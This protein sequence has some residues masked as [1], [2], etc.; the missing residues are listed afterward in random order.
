MSDKAPRKNVISVQNEDAVADNN[1]SECSIID[2]A[3]RRFSR[4]SVGA[5]VLMT[6]LSKP[7]FGAQ[8]LSNMLSGNLSDPNRGT[9][10]KGDSPGG[11]KQPGGM[12]KG[13]P[14]LTA[15]SEAGFVYGEYDS[16]KGNPSQ[17][18]SYINGSLAGMAPFDSLLMLNPGDSTKPLRVILH[19]YPGSLNAGIITAYL[20]AALSQNAGTFSYIFTTEQVKGLVNGGIPLPPNTN[21]L[22]DLLYSTW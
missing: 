17:F 20:N 1:S 8:C 6:V 21:D 2:P 22:H 7:V 15:W 9:C 4:L 18:D 19:E 3:R 10:V 11:W 16:T 5:P 14:T 13:I 12:I